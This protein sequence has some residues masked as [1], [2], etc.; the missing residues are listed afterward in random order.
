MLRI[1]SMSTL[2]NGLYYDIP[3]VKATERKVVCVHLAGE[4]AIDIIVCGLQIG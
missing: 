2:S 3:A 1:V 4:T